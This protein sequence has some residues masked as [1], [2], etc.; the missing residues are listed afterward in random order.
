M[1]NYN[2]GVLSQVK[3]QLLKQQAL[4]RQQGKVPPTKVGAIFYFYF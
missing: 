3:T 1:P 2:I 4:A